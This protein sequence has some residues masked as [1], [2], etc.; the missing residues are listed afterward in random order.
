MTGLQVVISENTEGYDLIQ[1]GR[2]TTGCSVAAAGNLVE[3]P[4]G[5]QVLELKATQLRLIGEH[6][7]IAADVR[8]ILLTAPADF[9]SILRPPLSEI[10][11]HNRKVGHVQAAVTRLTTR[12]KRSGTVWSSCEKS[13]TYA[14]VLM[15]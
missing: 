12:Y 3:S 14:L 4:G 5:K 13:H 2:I 6:T 1:N 9:C 15:L 7:C 11:H 8:S 10:A